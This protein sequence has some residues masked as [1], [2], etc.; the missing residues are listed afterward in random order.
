[1][2]TSRVKRLN[3]RSP[4]LDIEDYPVALATLMKQAPE[5]N[6]WLHEIKLDGYRLVALLEGSA[7]R[8]RQARLF[9]RS[10][11]DWTARFPAVADAIAKLP[12]KSAVIDGELVA[13]DE[14]GISRFQLLQNALSNQRRPLVYFAFD[15][16][17]LDGE[18][19]RPLALR[20]R[21][22]RLARL[23]SRS[24]GII[25]LSDHVAGRGPDFFDE[26]CG[27]G[28]EGIISKRADR[29]YRSGRT[30]DWLKIKCIGREELVIGGFTDSPAVGRPLGSLLVGYF[31]RSQFVYAG[32]VGT[33]FDTA[34]LRLL[35]KRLEKL[36]HESSP[37][38]ELPPREKVRGTNWVEPRLVAQVEFG[39]WTDAGILRHASFQGLREDKS[40]KS[41]KRPE[42]LAQ[43]SE[44]S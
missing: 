7:A 33:G 44:P 18:D 11:L 17:H 26:C 43:R 1:M 22:A 2:A 21:K 39:S 8:D 37:F 42:S 14:R 41:V 34:T 40:A 20:H 24:R 3:S 23:L 9:T 31:D 10:Q 38:A 5:G 32:R 13:L 35:R 28:L 29:P 16:L 36:A 25:R 27:R 12:V 4:A 30:L 19:L 6:D 15:L